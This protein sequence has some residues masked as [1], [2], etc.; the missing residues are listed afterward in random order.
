MDRRKHRMTPGELDQ[1]IDLVL[2]Q[3]CSLSPPRN[4]PFGE[5]SARPRPGAVIPELGSHRVEVARGVAIA[6]APAPDIRCIDSGLPGVDS[7]EVG[8]R[9]RA[10][11]CEG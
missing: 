9:T 5:C 6:L 11:G 4:R 1:K 8:R 3:V 2:R 10:A 7:Y